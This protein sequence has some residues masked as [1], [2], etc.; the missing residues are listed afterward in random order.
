MEVSIGPQKN[1]I[2]NLSTS[3]EQQQ[4]QQNLL[5]RHYPRQQQQQQQR[6]QQQQLQLGPLSLLLCQMQ[7]GYLN[8]T[9]S[10]NRTISI[11]PWRSMG[12]KNVLCF[13]GASTSSF[14]EGLGMFTVVTVRPI[15]VAYSAICFPDSEVIGTTIEQDKQLVI[16]WASTIF[17][18]EQR[19]FVKAKGNGIFDGG[20]K[21]LPPF[22]SPTKLP[23]AAEEE[24]LYA[25]GLMG[26]GEWG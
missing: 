8:L 14:S 16:F 12:D 6:Q 7:Q 10:H 4:Q 17:P 22:P 23:P 24:E 5:L 3:D 21:V 18:A 15:A 13:A 1:M 19:W 11:S 20:W 2:G 26:N 25:L 9:T